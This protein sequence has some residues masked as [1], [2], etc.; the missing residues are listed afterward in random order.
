MSLTAEQRVNRAKG[1]GGTDAAPALGVS[2]RKSTLQLYLEKR[3]EI[4]PDWEETED[5]RWGRLLEPVVRQ[6]YA[7]KTKRIVR[8]PEKTIF[9][10]KYTWMMAHPDGISE[11]AK[12]ALNVHDDTAVKGYEGKTARFDEEWGD[13]GTDEVP[14]DHLLQ[15]Q[16][17]MI[18]LDLPVYDLAVLIGREFRLYEIPAD[19][20][21]QQMI[22]DAEHDLWQRV[23]KGEPP[24]PDFR[25]ADASRIIRKLYPGT[26]G[27]IIAAT[28]EQ[29]ALRDQWI[30]QA[31][32]E[33]TA[34]KSAEAYKAQ[35]L[36]EMA[37]AAVLA[38]PDGKG[39]RRKEINRVGYSVEP[40]TYID[41]RLVNHR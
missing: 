30:E 28:Q 36:Y 20:E 37:E 17:Y 33:K 40:T 32:I 29:I 39:L 11:P 3:G 19:R 22:I 16:H 31:S 9:H 13:Q 15:T 21:L 25:R 6:W 8:L 10:E 24:E 41:A 34:K 18:V 12:P 5:S 23:L 1:F 26:D 7:E 4:E 38:F 2:K 35:L 14:Q 27:Q